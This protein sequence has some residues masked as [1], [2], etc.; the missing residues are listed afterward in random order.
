[1]KLA[2]LQSQTTPPDIHVHAKFEDNRSKTTQVRAE[3]NEALTDG[4]SKFP[5]G[6]T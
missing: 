5:E 1:M 4:H 3:R 6:I 2:H